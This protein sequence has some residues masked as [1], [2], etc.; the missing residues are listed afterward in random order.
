MVSRLNRKVAAML[1][2]RFKKVG[3]LRFLT[4]GRLTVS[5]SVA[6]AGPRVEREP[7]K[8]VTVGMLRAAFANGYAKAVADAHSTFR[9][10]E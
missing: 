7:R 4:I 1:Q 2:Y 3:G 6:K 10:C 5:W 8:R 9:A